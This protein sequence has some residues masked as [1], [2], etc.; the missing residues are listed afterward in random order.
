MATNVVSSINVWPDFPN[1]LSDVTT[2]KQMPNRFDDV[3][4]MCGDLSDC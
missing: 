2:R 3:F 1:T 4:R